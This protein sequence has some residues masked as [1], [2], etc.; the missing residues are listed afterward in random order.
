MIDDVNHALGSTLTW[1]MI[2]QWLDPHISERK[3]KSYKSLFNNFRVG[4]IIPSISE[5]HFNAINIAIDNNSPH[6]IT[7]SHIMT[8]YMTLRT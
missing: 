7:A 5:V 8:L 2:G 1:E 6:F 3:F 4:L